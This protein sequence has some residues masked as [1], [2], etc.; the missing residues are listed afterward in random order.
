[1]T[2]RGSSS[3]G[4]VVKFKD[5]EVGGIYRIEKVDE[6]T[7]RYTGPVGPGFLVRVVGKDKTLKMPACTCLEAPFAWDRAPPGDDGVRVGVVWF[8]SS[9]RLGAVD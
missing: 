8:M 2:G 4:K 9:D 3:K 7:R 6:W 1:V 5:I